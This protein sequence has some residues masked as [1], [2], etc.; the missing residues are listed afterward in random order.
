MLRGDP[1]QIRRS[2]HHPAARARR[3]ADP[4]LQ[5]PE[6]QDDDDFQRYGAHGSKKLAHNRIPRGASGRH[7]LGREVPNLRHQSPAA[8]ADPQPNNLHHRQA[9]QRIIRSR[10]LGTQVLAQRL[11]R[12]LGPVWRRHP[13]VSGQTLGEAADAARLRGRQRRF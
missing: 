2:L 7:L 9:R 4:G 8:A 3:R 5:S 12:G 6:R 1:S 13:P 10:S 11:Q